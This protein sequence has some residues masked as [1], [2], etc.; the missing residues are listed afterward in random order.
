MFVY[1]CICLYMILHVCVLL[2]RNTQKTAPPN[3]QS[4][5]WS[6]QF[7]PW[8]EFGTHPYSLHAVEIFKNFFIAMK[9]ANNKKIKNVII[10]K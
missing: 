3:G 2:V 10:A 6:G 8:S 9:M 4:D 1:D 5:F 7:G